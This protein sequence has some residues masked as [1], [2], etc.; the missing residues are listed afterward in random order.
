MKVLVTFYHNGG[1]S[2]NLVAVTQGNL[3]NYMNH[4]E[5]PILLFLY[6]LGLLINNRG[7]DV[8]K[9]ILGK[10]IGIMLVKKQVGNVY[11]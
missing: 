6:L 2:R 10:V 7:G 4:M 5:P 11:V 3:L 1:F 8:G 9:E